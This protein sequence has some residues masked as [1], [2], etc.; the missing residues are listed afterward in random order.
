[1][2]AVAD[3]VEPEDLRV[4]DRGDHGGREELAQHRLAA[5]RERLRQVGDR[6]PVE[7]AQR[8]VEVV[9]PRV[10]ELE[11][12]HRPAEDLLRAGMRGVCRAEP[13]AG[14]QHVAGEEQV[15][16]ALVDE[17]GLVHLEAGALEP[18]PVGGPFVGALR[19]A[20][21]HGQHPAVDHGGAVGGEDH[22][23]QAGERLDLVDPV[24]QVEEDLAQ[25]RPLADGERGVVRRRRIH[26]G[27]D[28]VVDREVGRPA[29]EEPHAATL[30]AANG[31]NHRKHLRAAV[32]RC[33]CAGPLRR[34]VA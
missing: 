23:G 20:E 4:L 34:F 19:V 30:E 15:A 6:V 33:V 12:D 7:H 2:A 5:G 22:V 11:R 13:R 24:A 29:H 27:V 14:Q 16:L 28:P 3:R 26:P 25:R 10:D 32:D 21:L 1:V 31:R 17:L 8:R 18:R 9:E